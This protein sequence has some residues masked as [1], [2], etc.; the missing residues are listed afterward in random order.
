M[1]AKYLTLIEHDNVAE[2]M[3]TALRKCCD[4]APTSLLWNLIHLSKSA[5]SLYLDYIWVPLKVAEAMNQE[6]F[7]KSLK[8][9]S[10]RFR[11]DAKTP[12]NKVNL[13]EIV[14]FDIIFEMFSDEDWQG[15][16]SYLTKD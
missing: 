10:L 4:S 9:V 7:W 6:P 1:R 3:H 14:C 16:A 13:H 8:K 2:A 12:N 5:W 11:E 15:F